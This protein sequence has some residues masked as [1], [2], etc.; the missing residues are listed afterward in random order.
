M[1]LESLGGQ[2]FFTNI[3]PQLSLKLHSVLATGQRLRGMFFE[4]FKW[5]VYLI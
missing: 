4:G 1:T 3:M 5:C 2:C